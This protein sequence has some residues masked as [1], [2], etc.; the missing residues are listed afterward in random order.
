MKRLN[1]L[2]LSVAA[3]ALALPMAPL[4]GEQPEPLLYEIPTEEAFD[5]PVGLDFSSEEEFDFNSEEFQQMLAQ[6]QEQMEQMKSQMT[7]EM[8]ASIERMEEEMKD[9]GNRLNTLRGE[10]AELEVLNE[11]QEAAIQELREKIGAQEMDRDE[12]VVKIEQLTFMVSELAPDDVEQHQDELNKQQEDLTVIDAE[13]A[14][15]TQMREEK[16]ALKSETEAKIAAHKATILALEAEMT[17]K[18][19]ANSS[20]FGAVFGETAGGDD[21]VAFA[22]DEGDTLVDD[23]QEAADEADL[24]DVGFALDTEVDDEDKGVGA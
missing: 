8:R 20:D 5:E 22:S 1:A 21:S 7:P 10:L 19:E 15:L 4:V 23:S 9:L 18:S 12:L 2:V 16:R 11:E 17:Q 14:T 6:L 13:I 24:S 3:L